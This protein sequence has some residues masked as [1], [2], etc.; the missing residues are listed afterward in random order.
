MAKLLSKTVHRCVQSNI[1][2][3]STKSILM[4]HMK[5]YFDCCLYDFNVW[6]ER[7]I[8]IGREGWVLTA[9][10]PTNPWPQYSLSTVFG[11]CRHL[12]TIALHNKLIIFINLILIIIM[13]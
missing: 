8:Y 10:V 13:F 1:L 6:T 5:I 3:K 2:T 12:F 9:R 4:D 7:H 11:S